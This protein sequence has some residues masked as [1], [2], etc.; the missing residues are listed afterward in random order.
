MGLL[1]IF[2]DF[3]FYTFITYSSL[4]AQEIR[5]C[6]SLS[7]FQNQVY[8]FIYFIYSS[9]FAVS[10]ILTYIFSALNIY[11]LVLF[12]IIINLNLKRRLFYFTSSDLKERE[13]SGRLSLQRRAE[14]AGEQSAA[15]REAVREGGARRQ[16]GQA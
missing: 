6:H 15:L 8:S 11:I 5:H 2:V 1:L 9:F 10:S 14:D 12:N 4:W 3:V 16:L 7:V 13:V